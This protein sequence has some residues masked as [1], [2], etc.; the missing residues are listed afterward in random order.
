MVAGEI[1]RPLLQFE[2]SAGIM[3]EIRLNMEI[4]CMVLKLTDVG[5]EH[6]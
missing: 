3:T 5:G 4:R 6:R 1:S 2:T